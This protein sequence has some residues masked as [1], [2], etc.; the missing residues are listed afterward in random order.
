MKLLANENFPMISKRLIKEAGF[1]ITHIGEEAF[2]IMDEEV[3]ELSIKEERVILT[4]DSDY[5]T[6][7]F[8]EGYR[9][10]GVIYLRFKEFQAQ[11]P[12]ELLLNL[13]SDKNIEFEHNFTVI[14]SNNII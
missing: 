5:G 1:D 7:I 10:Y 12:A 13:F 2:G 6:L 4:F 9:P 3:V 11:M 14:D 8:R